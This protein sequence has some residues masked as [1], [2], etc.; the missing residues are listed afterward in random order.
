MR[1]SRSEAFSIKASDNSESGHICSELLT[2]TAL[3]VAAPLHGHN[4]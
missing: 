3:I 1:K 2:I 4:Y